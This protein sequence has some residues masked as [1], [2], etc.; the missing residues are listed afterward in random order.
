MCILHICLQFCK[1]THIYIYTYTHTFMNMYIRIHTRPHEMTYYVV[2]Y[3]G[4]Y[5][6]MYVCLF[7]C[8]FAC[9]YVCLFVCLFF[10]CLY[11][12]IYMYTPFRL[13]LAVRCPAR[14]RR[15]SVF[16]PPKIAWKRQTC[17]NTHIYTWRYVRTYLVR[18]LWG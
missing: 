15:T 16:T 3:V 12:Y 9:L 14:W 10:L 6:C 18:P 17:V 11:V 13:G 7:V 4:R 1:C 8:M 5:V 2:W